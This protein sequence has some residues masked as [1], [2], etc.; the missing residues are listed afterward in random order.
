MKRCRP[1]DEDKKKAGPGPTP[2]RQRT[3]QNEHTANGERQTDRQTE[4]PFTQQRHQEPKT[5]I[6]NTTQPEQQICFVYISSYIRTSTYMHTRIRVCEKTYSDVVPD[7][8]DGTIS[9]SRRGFV[10]VEPNQPK[11]L[12]AVLAKTTKKAFRM[13][14]LNVVILAFVTTQIM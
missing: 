9:S 4:R 6:I 7:D 8:H 10:R 2:E 5:F 13:L 3:S 1:S 12:V 14:M 11:R